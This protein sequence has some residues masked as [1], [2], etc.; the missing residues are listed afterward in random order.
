VAVGTVALM[1]YALGRNLARTDTVLV[2][3]VVVFMTLSLF[4]D[5]FPGP[6]DMAR[7]FGNEGL[8]TVAAL[9]VVAAGLTE[10]GGVNLATER[11]LGRPKGVARAQ[12][13][14]MLPVASLSAFLNNT[15]VVAMFLPVV[16]EWCKRARISPSKLYLPLSYAAVLGGCCTLIGTSTNLVV[17]GLLISAGL[18]RMGF[19][20]IGAVGLPAAILGILF[21][22][23]TSRWLLRDRVAASEQHADPREYT[24]EML[25]QPGSPLAGQ[26]IEA[27]GLRNLPGAY[28]VE[29]DRDGEVIAAVGPEQILRA[30]DRLIFAGVVGSVVELQKI[31]GLV[32]ATNQVFKLGDTRANRVL[33]EAVVSNACPLV[34]NTIRAGR[35][36]TRYDAA[37]IAVHRNGRRVDRKIGDI[38]LQAG[39]TLLLE[40]HPRF[41]ELYRDRRDFFLVSPVADSRPRRHERAWIALAIVVAM[42]VAMSFESRIAVLNSALLAAGLML[43]TGCVR[44]EVARRSIDWGTLV[45]IGAAF[46]IG[47]AMA[48]SGAAD[49]LGDRLIG[50]LQF[51]GPWGVL[52]GV[53]LTTLIFTE[54][55]TN[56]AAA[57]L[58]FPIARSAAETMGV[59]FMPFAVVLAVAA[60]AGFATP[61]GYQT[62]LMVYGPGGYRFSDFLRVGIPMDLLVMAV[63]VGLAPVFFPFYP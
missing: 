11:L 1:L 7:E 13:R 37:V 33:V 45:A 39:D 5:R 50:A 57:A 4:S 28:L 8:L 23:G 49:F 63:A 51:M 43:L 15:P 21:I 36:R 25:V 19:W 42:V 46:G 35:F 6:R 34:G 52:A 30:N 40:T 3:G 12:L 27:A 29:V 48:T 60:S 61:L 56:N 18:P 22:V 59:D 14:L 32:P 38:E 10:T 2:G 47:K 62:H 53:Y 54:L 31:R 24:V 41:P 26:T 58:A 17:Q 16:G 44:G 55:V 9:F 20:T